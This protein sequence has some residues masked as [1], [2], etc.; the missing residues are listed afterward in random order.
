MFEELV[1]RFLPGRETLSML[2]LP[3]VCASLLAAVIAGWMKQ[4]G[5]RTPYTRK[6]FHFLVFTLAGLL[7][8]Y[9]GLKAATLLGMIISFLVLLA[10]IVGN[11]WWFYLAMARETDQPH[12]KKF[13]LLPLL[14]TIAGGIAS[15]LLFPSTAYIGYFVGGWGDAV[16][17]P[18]GTRWGRHRYTVPT[19]FGVPA[20]RSIEGSVAVMA[21]GTIITAII[22]LYATSLTAGTCILYALICGLSSSL[23]EAASSHGLDN[24]TIQICAAGVI[25][26]LV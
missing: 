17:E 12:E 10:V 4:R 2:L 19:L 16:A 20:T 23:V 14:A 3:V 24:F 13:I 18:V 6:I 5:V 15:N 11:R 25:H 7:H 9:Y 8:Y 1:S 26:W 22:L 21:A